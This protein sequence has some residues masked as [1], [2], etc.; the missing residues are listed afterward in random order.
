VCD[1][2]PDLDQSTFCSKITDAIHP[3]FGRH[4]LANERIPVSETVL[5][6]NPYA[7]V[8][9]PEKSGLYCAQCFKKLIAAIPCPK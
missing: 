9:Y 8:L 5:V 3:E 7:A 2:T 4:I 6:E 1:L